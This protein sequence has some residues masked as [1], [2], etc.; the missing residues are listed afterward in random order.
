MAL[1][2]LDLEFNQGHNSNYFEILQ[3]SVVKTNL[4]WEQLCLFDRLVEPQIATVVNKNVRKLTGITMKELKRRGLPLS[5]IVKEMRAN[6]FKGDITHILT[7]GKSDVEIFKSNCKKNN[8]DYSFLNKIE[9]V[10]IQ[11]LYRCLN[12]LKILPSLHNV[13]KDM[14]FCREHYGLHDV[15]R[16]IQVSKEIGLDNIFN[17]KSLTRSHNIQTSFNK[18]RKS[19]RKNQE[20]LCGEGM[21]SIFLEGEI[22]NINK[23]EYSRI[24]LLRC[25]S[26]NN[27]YKAIA[28][29][30]I[31]RKP[32]SWIKDVL[33]L[34]DTEYFNEA[35]DIIKG[36]IYNIKE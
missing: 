29:S 32:I 9:V 5:R 7:W 36:R 1:L 19:L 3:I 12:D 20:C 10:D 24:Y 8:V 13:T 27:K 17:S 11:H 33:R 28:N 4:F 31:E 2:F 23:N 30:K 34:D 22:I 26:C 18:V 6:I 14:E 25:R 15:Y 35:N 16:L 21:L